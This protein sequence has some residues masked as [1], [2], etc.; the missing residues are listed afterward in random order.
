[1]RTTRG[2]TGEKFDFQDIAGP[3][4]QEVDPDKLFVFAVVDG[5]SSN[6][7]KAVIT[8]AETPTAVAK[9]QDAQITD[10]L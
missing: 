7:K 1:M 3:C 8:A 10:L 2:T 9:S 4:Y 5:R 6:C